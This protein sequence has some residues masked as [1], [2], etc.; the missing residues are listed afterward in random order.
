VTDDEKA[1]L[2]PLAERT[3]EVQAMA[4]ERLT[5]RLRVLQNAVQYAVNRLDHDPAGPQQPQVSGDLAIALAYSR[6]PK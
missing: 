2:Y 5:E 4:I 3:I 6:G 1:K